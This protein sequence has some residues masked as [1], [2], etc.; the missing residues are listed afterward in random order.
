LYTLIK[1]RKDMRSR[2][3]RTRM[4]KKNPRKGCSR[5]HVKL[6]S[7]LFSWL[8]LLSEY[9]KLEKQSLLFYQAEK[10]E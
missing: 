8:L 9:R 2:E 3:S 5:D 1:K 7:K 4:E 6:A 10:V